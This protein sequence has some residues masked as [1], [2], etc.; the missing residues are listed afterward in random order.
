MVLLHNYFFY[1]FST[2]H[3]A[4][5]L[6]MLKVQ[7]T[8]QEQS[9]QRTGRAGRESEGYCYRI[10]TRAQYE[11]MQ[12]ST[13]PEVQRAN[14]TTVVLQLLALGI[15]AMHFDFIDKPPKESVLA[16]FE[17]LK[18]LGAVDAVESQSLTQLGKKMVQFPLDPR[19]SK[20]L[21]SA[22]EYGCLEE[23]GRL[24]GAQ[25]NSY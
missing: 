25:C 23:V 13:T 21:L 19:F 4:T 17:Q 20:I 16:A 5:G 8:S 14:L 10:Y 6:D 2:Y 1:F 3:P 11:L 22:Q 12:K 24:K 15:H 18:M 9:W 7:R